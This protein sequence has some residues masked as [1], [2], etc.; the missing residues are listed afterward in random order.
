MVVG[1]GLPSMNRF[2]SVVAGF[3]AT[4]NCKVFTVSYCLQYRSIV[5]GQFKVILTNTGSDS[6]VCSSS[7]IAMTLKV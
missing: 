2:I 3:L 1:K 6:L 7:I 4:A 5:G